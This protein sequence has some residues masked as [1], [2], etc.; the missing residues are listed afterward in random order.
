MLSVRGIRTGISRRLGRGRGVIHRVGVGEGGGGDTGAMTRRRPLPAGLPPHFTIT[1][2][3]AA[4]VSPRGLRSPEL[5]APFRG[6]RSAAP[7]DAVDRIR[8]YALKLRR[9]EEVSHASAI[10]L[11][12][13]WVPDRLRDAVDVSAVRP[14]GRPRGAGVRGHE[15]DALSGWHC[16]GIPIT[17]PADA[18][19]QLGVSVTHRELVIAADSLLRRKN[20]ILRRADLEAAVQRWAKRRGVVALRAA[21]ERARERTDSVAETVLRLDAEDAGLPPLEVNGVI[22]DEHGRF[23]TFGDLVDRERQVLL[24][25]DGEQHR[26]S[27]AQYARD[28]DRLEELARLGWR[29]IRVNKSHRGPA[30]R[31]QLDRVRAALTARGWRP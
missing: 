1:T 26:T 10:L 22:L 17:S 13:G 7:P 18:W 23:I 30:R 2:A 28:V 31:H 27:D 5:A 6:I 8:A 9:G 24:E 4:G 20:P 29:V 15:T 12:G 3:T 19:C 16:E 21:V 11:A 14:T 25:Y